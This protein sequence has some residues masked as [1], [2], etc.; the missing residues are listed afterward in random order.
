MVR[1]MVIDDHSKRARVAPVEAVLNEASVVG[2]GEFASIGYNRA[3]PKRR[4]DGQ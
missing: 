4:N 3:Y 2:A 1:V